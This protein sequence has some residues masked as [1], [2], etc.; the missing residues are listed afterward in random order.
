MEPRAGVRMAAREGR[1]GA[2][3]TPRGACNDGARIVCGVSPNDTAS[4][5][6]VSGGGGRE[7]LHGTLV[8]PA[9]DAGSARSRRDGVENE[10]VVLRHRRPR[11]VA[12]RVGSPTS[13]RQW[14][15]GPAD[16]RHVGHVLVEAHRGCDVACGAALARLTISGSQGPAGGVQATCA[17]AA[18]NAAAIRRKIL[19]MGVGSGMNGNYAEMLEDKVSLWLMDT[20]RLQPR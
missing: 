3:G 10:W 15:R 5:L 1:G 11:N 14:V 7:V 4:R 20:K 2:V 8:R 13:G 18:G 17:I 16:G 12:Q 9:R 19:A 6:A